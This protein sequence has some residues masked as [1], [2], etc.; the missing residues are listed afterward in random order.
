[1]K[2]MKLPPL[3]KTDP[4]GSVF[5][6]ENRRLHSQEPLPA[7]AG[8]AS[9]GEACDGDPDERGEGGGVIAVGGAVSANGAKGR[10]WAGEEGCDPGLGQGAEHGDRDGLLLFNVVIC[11]HADVVADDLADR[12]ECGYADAVADGLGVLL[13]DFVEGP[14]EFIAV[15]FVGIAVVDDRDA[16]LQRVFDDDVA[17]AHV[18][19]VAQG[20]RVFDYA[21]RE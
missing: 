8:A 14:L 20:D 12:E 13:V 16:V 5:V 18:T 4:R 6:S 9:C 3:T 11:R 10:G 15:A 7:D 17:Q 1:M 2:L 21:A 19:G